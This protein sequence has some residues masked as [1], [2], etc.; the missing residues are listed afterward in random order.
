MDQ[1][2]RRGRRDEQD[3]KVRAWFND[4]VDF[5]IANDTDFA[6]WPLVGWH[7]NR[8][9]NGWGLAHWDAAGNRMFIDDGDDW[10][11]PAWHRLVGAA[12]GGARPVDTWRMLG[13][14]HGDLVQS[15]RMRG[16]PDW[17]PGA[18]K[19][20]CPDGQRLI[21]L[22]HTGSRGLCSDTGGADQWDAGY[23]VVRDERHV[24]DDWAPGFTKFQCP[25]DSFVT[26]YA[27]RSADLSSVLCGKVGEPPGTTGRTVWFDRADARPPDAHGG[28]FASGHFKGQCADGENIAGVAWS[29]RVYSPTRE[30]DALLCQTIR[31]RDE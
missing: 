24:T 22:S 26:G 8:Q 19:A 6:Y 12:A 13:V 2:V 4:F 5:L 18:R 9:G 14:D 30:P 31:P 27:A 11:A 23:E 29:A 28:D 21:G 10:R 1:R 3:P 7:Q 16:E 20:V 25:P 17:D 15:A